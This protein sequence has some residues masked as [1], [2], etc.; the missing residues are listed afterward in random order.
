MKNSVV[1]LVGAVVAVAAVSGIQAPAAQAKQVR[2]PVSFSYPEAIFR[3]VPFTFK[4]TV[5]QKLNATCTFRT[6]DGAKIVGPKSAAMKNGKA[7]VRLALVWPL[8]TREDGSEWA[9][10]S[11]CNSTK[12]WAGDYAWITGFER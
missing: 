8:D 7:S 10:I 11:E 4:V 9:I 2:Y 5:K 12:A 6:Q 1:K 3:G